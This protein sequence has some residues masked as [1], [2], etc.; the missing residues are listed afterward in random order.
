MNIIKKIPHLFSS[1]KLTI[2]LLFLTILLV[3]FGT[4]FQVEHGLYLVQKSMF[5]T[6]IITWHPTEDYA[7]PIF[8]G[9]RLLGVLLLLNLIFAHFFR[10]KWTWKKSGI[11]LTHFGL[12][13]L[14]IGSGITSF[15]AVESQMAIQEGETKNYTTSLDET[16]LAVIS[17]QT[18]STQ[19]VVSIPQ[20]L[21]KPDAVIAD[22]A[23]PFTLK[24]NYFWKNADLKMNTTGA[25]PLANRGIGLQLI[26]TPLP[27]NTKNTA[28]N[29]VTAIVDVR[30]KNNT[31]LGI[32]LLSSKL[33]APQTLTVADKTYTLFIRP[34]RYYLPFTVTLLD[35]KHDLYPGTNI[36][37]NFSSKVEVN[38]PAA[39]TKSDFLIFMNNPLR[40]EGKTFYQASFGN[41][42][43]LSVFQVVENAG[44]LIPYIS[45]VI[46]A[47]GLLIQF[48]L[49]L[50][51]FLVKRKKSDS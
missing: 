50:W 33:G 20:T 49:S 44:W 5:Q 16:E 32:F 39:K 28:E 15:F 37:K 27:F 36:P 12:I 10:F 21:L 41:N 4:L 25:A 19:Q 38:H 51:T 34:K 6:W 14:L 40:Y 26:A 42:D 8:P 43:T 1:L 24:I 17:D 30:D 48:S 13:F 31:S 29:A 47:I 9:G 45:S 22:K 35:F 7:I 2:V 3:F 18:D 11:W 46:M 23:I